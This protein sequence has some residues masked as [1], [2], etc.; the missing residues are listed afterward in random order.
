[1]LGS[2]IAP[3]TSG[4]VLGN[5]VPFSGHRQLCSGA[6]FIDLLGAHQC[7]VVAWVTSAWQSPALNGVSKDHRR[8]LA[9]RIGLAI[10]LQH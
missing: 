7:R 8:A 4:G 10:S 2:L 1:M 3:T 6:H 5:A 9:G